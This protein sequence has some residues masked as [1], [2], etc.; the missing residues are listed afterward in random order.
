VEKE[1]HHE[2]ALG[3][4]CDSARN[5]VKACRFPVAEERAGQRNQIQRDDDQQRTE[6]PGQEFAVE[7]K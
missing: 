6:V 3:I 2:D 1:D 4:R 5:R 7:R